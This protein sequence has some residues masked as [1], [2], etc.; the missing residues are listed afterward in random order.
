[1]SEIKL[2]YH[3][4]LKRIHYLSKIYL[5]MNKKKQIKTERPYAIDTRIGQKVKTSE[6]NRT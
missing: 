5:E 2:Y 3:N 1:M 6:R 4:K